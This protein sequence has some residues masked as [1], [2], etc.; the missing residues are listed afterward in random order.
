MEAR[1]GSFKWRT[2]K[3]QIRWEFHCERV[4]HYNGDHTN[5]GNEDEKEYDDSGINVLEEAC[6]IAN[7]NL[8]W[9]LTSILRMICL[10]N[11]LAKHQILPSFKGISTTIDDK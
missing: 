4:D 2:F 11:P 10:K 9:I 5:G 6:G 7:K 3:K 1:F 8:G